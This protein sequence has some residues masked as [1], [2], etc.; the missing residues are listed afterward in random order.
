MYVVCGMWCTEWYRG[1]VTEVFS[2]KNMIDVAYEDGEEDENLSVSCIRPFVPYYVG[3][4]VEVLGIEDTIFYRGII[5]EAYPGGVFDIETEEE[6]G[7]RKFVAPRYMR[8]F[9]DAEA[10]A[11]ERGDVIEALFDGGDM[12]F[13]GKI[14]RKRRNGSYDISYFD[15][16]FETAV[17]PELIQLART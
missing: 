9:V 12:W 17:P 7:L 11:F 10:V 14:A 5:V 4:I 15:G 1:T 3:E 8:R 6:A 2:A 16:D 13:Q